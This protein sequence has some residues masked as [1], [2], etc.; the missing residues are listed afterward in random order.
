MA[1]YGA[2]ADHHPIVGHT[3]SQLRAAASLLRRNMMRAGQF[4]L[5]GL[6]LMLAA[7]S[8]ASEPTVDAEPVPD[9]MS[10]EALTG[11]VDDPDMTPE[12]EGTNPA[13]TE[14]PDV[15]VTVVA[16]ETEPAPEPSPMPVSEE[17][18]APTS[19][20][21]FGFE[22]AV[23]VARTLSKAPFEEPATIPQA[24]ANLNYDTY[25]R[26]QTT[27]AAMAW[28]GEGEDTRVLFDPRGYLFTHDV[29]INIVEDGEVKA[30]PYSAEDFNFLDLPLPDA[31]K[32]NLG[33]SGFRLL[34]PI[35]RSG[36]FDEVVSF[37]GAS[38]FRAL[39]ACNVFGASARSATPL[40]SA[41]L[42]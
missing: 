4:G 37:K 23:E 17:L 5:A 41:H 22:Q 10:P 34:A 25:R 1:R 11:A 3:V 18:P 38:F 28:G 27:E 31:A 42:V 15:E 24:A 30:R 14:E 36:K 26:I 8:G 21:A 16:A 33:F 20:S 9:A 35:N 39:G 7:C 40:A 29:K 6:F 12:T 32:E 13:S 2:R 19:D